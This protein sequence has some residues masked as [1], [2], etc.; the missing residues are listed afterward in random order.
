VQL[1]VLVDVER[2]EDGGLGA[3]VDVDGQRGLRRQQRAAELLRE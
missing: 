3:A 1:A 2:G